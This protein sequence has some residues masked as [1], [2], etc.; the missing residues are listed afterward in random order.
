MIPHIIH[1]LQESERENASPSERDKYK[2]PNS[3]RITKNPFIR[4]SVG[5]N[6]NL[7]IHSSASDFENS[8]AADYKKTTVLQPK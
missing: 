1:N 2:L 5:F 4:K 7:I 3:T 6:H 8:A